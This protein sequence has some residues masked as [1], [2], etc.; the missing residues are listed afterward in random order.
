M[1]KEFYYK[2]YSN[3]ENKKILLNYLL[4]K[5]PIKFINEL[6][7]YNNEEYNN[8]VIVINDFIKYINL[9]TDSNTYKSIYLE[10]IKIDKILKNNFLDEDN[11][12][13]NIY[14]KYL[15]NYLF[16]TKNNKTIFKVQTTEKIG[17]SPYMTYT[18]I[19]NYL[20][21]I[22][23]K[24]SFDRRFTLEEI[25]ELYNKKKYK[26]EMNKLKN[27]LIMSEIHYE[28]LK[29]NTNIKE[30]YDKINHGIDEMSI[31]PKEESLDALCYAYEKALNNKININLETTNLEHIY[32][33]IKK[34]K[35]I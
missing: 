16:D 10:L 8:T 32:T 30:L 6:N 11:V 20:N 9:K 33:R 24:S 31:I 19:L 26:E 34:M 4:G 28:R 23:S 25:Y 3:I 2:D 29:N 17:M 21:F 13:L 18:I 22:A 27:F 5:Y 1:E 15:P 35:T 14:L 7:K 12:I